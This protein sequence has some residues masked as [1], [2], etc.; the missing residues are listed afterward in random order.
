[1]V[2]HS[3][4][5]AERDGIAPQYHRA[6]LALMRVWLT[7]VVLSGCDDSA[8]QKSKDRAGSGETERGFPRDPP[9]KHVTAAAFSP[10]NK[11]LLTGYLIEGPLGFELDLNLLDLWDVERGVRL[12]APGSWDVEGKR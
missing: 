2:A 6:G 11:L 7:V 9:T 1:M 8:Q 12:S 5:R 3:K 4:R 10:D